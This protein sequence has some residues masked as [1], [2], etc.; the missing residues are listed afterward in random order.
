MTTLFDKYGG[1]PAVGSIVKSFYKSVLI[2]P[3]LKTYF[4]NTDSKKLI[5]HQIVF[6]SH[7][8]GKPSTHK[9]DAQSVLK[10]A[11]AGK[12][13]SQSAFTEI[14]DI[15]EAV[16]IAHNFEPDDIAAVMAIIQEFETAIV[17]LP[18]I[19]RTAQVQP[20]SK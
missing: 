8:L 10:K 18:N 4:Q 13:I 5:E 15:L 7:L 20:A 6:I 17:E 11:H 2:N 9:F 16:L 14:K 19:T 1:L 3:K 12:R